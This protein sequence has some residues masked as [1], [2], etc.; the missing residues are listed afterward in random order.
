MKGIRI[1]IFK[2]LGIMPVGA[3]HL[4]RMFDL[5]P[6][7]LG[8]GG[9]FAGVGEQSVAVATIDAVQFFKPVQIAKVS[10]IK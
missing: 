4:G 5:A 7:T 8:S 1:P 3:L 6:M 10:A 2:K 9:D